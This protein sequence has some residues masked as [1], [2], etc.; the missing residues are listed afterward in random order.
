MGRW[1]GN[2]GYE[3]D[4]RGFLRAAAA[5]VAGLA[6]ALRGAFWGSSRASAATAPEA[7]PADKTNH[8][9][10]IECW[11]WDADPS[12]DSQCPGWPFN[13]PFASA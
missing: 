10:V 4:R 7:L 9:Y 8:R 5:G 3:S 2:V 1:D 13:L 6:L 11:P 12:V